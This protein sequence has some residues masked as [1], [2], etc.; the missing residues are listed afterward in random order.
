MPRPSNHEIE[1]YYFEQ[2]RQHFPLPI[3]CVEYKDKPDVL[4]HGDRLLGVE[5]ANLYLS[6]GADPASEQ[7]QSKRRAEAVRKA[8]DLHL[9]AGGRKCELTVS[10]NPTHPINDVR[11]V[12][13]SLVSVAAK[14]ET[15]NSGKGPLPKQ[16]VEITPEAS[17]VYYN[18][19]EY[20]DACW[21]VCQ[22]YTVQTL[23]VERLTEL[24]AAK[25]QLLPG[26][27]QCD[28]Y[29]LLLVVDFMDPAQDQEID[30]TPTHPSLNTLFERVI[31][32][33]PQ[34]SR[35]TVIPLIRR[36]G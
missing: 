15:E 32:Y 14:A 35:W 18:P 33:K 3:G 16:I 29:W 13:E 23:S 19:C 10:F 25:E 2:F 8:H 21:R 36:D 5:I 7:I 1:Q 26:Y 12:A 17:L 28:A 22:T 24:V 6:D 34:F 9:A 30:W 27:D 11:T 4:I 20:P 31:I